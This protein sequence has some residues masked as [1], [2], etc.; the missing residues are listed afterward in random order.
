LQVKHAVRPTRGLARE[1]AMSRT[2]VSILF[3]LLA[4]G[5]GPV[6]SAQP[7]AGGGG[8]TELHRVEVA[9]AS[10]L[11]VVM[12]LIERSGASTGARHYHPGGE[13]GFILEGDVTVTAENAQTLTLEAGTSFYQPP[14]KWHAV[15][16]GT[17]GSKAVV[18]RVLEKGQPMIVAVD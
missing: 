1:T 12:G 5:L 11:E 17:G 10:N 3:G 15:S 8:F 13:F 6:A 18:F 7:T 16:T 4:I 2:D 14:G 9:D